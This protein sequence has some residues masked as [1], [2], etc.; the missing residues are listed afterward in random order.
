MKHTLSYYVKSYAVIT[1]GSILYALAYNIFYAP[2]LVAMGGLTGLG[3]V[4]NALIPVLPVGTTVFVMN[5]PLFFWGGSSLAGTCWY[6]PC[7]P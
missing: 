2:N 5:V 4:L 7:M 1:L 6:P 3:Q